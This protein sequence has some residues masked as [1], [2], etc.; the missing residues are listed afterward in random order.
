MTDYWGRFTQAEK[1]KELARDT[2]HSRAQSA[3]DD[4]SGGR[5]SKVAPSKVTGAA[6][7]SYPAISSGP[8]SHGDLGAPDP[9][10]DQFGDVNAQEPVGSVQE[11]ERSLA[12]AAAASLSS[13]PVAAAE[14]PEV[15]HSPSSG[16]GRE[17]HLRGLPSQPSSRKAFRRF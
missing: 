8:Y 13:S 12:D 11:I 10:T 7:I 4:E 16:Q 1:R 9:H 5:F 2:F 6:P 3:L 15:S 17:V 14:R